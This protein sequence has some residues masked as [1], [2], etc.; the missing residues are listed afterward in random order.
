MTSNGFHLWGNF[1]M[2]G[3]RYNS[4]YNSRA[5]GRKRLNC[6]HNL[7]NTSSKLDSQRTIFF[8]FN[9]STIKFNKHL[10]GVIFLPASW[11]HVL[12]CVIQT[13]IHFPKKVWHQFPFSFNQI[14]FKLR[15]RWRELVFPTTWTRFSSSNYWIT[16]SKQTPTG[17][18]WK[19]ALMKV[20]WRL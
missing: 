5:K 10:A 20:R 19:G 8:F 1:L 4:S 18:V 7:S 14:Q 2:A 13:L 12:L 17:T 9:I 16:D 6:P 11:Q 15:S 3:E